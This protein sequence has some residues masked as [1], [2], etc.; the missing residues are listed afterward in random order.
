M[1]QLRSPRCVVSTTVGAEG[2]PVQDGRHLLLADTAPAFAGAVSRL[3]EC[4]DLR[5]EIGQAGRL[6][7]E[8]EFTWERAWESLDL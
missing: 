6:L 8:K 1:S 4:A 2:L 3:L 5:E 7:L